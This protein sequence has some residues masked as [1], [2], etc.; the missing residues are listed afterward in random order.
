[1]SMTMRGRGVWK[2]DLVSSL[3]QKYGRNGFS[4]K[5]AQRLPVFDYSGFMK[6]YHDNV[7]QK[8]GNTKPTIW[9]IADHQIKNFQSGGLPE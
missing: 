6:L 7:L 9:K 8:T 2:R 3:V 4:F 1:M 5:D